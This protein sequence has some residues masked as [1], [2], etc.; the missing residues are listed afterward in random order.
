MNR[1]VL[2]FAIAMLALS[3]CAKKPPKELPPAPVNSTGPVQPE[4]PTSAAV[5]PGSQEDFVASVAADRIF[6]ALDEASVDAEDRATLQ[7]QAGANT[8]WRLGS[9]APT[10]RKTRSLRSAWARTGSARSAMARNGPTRPARTKMLMPA[11]GAR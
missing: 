10:P 3:A 8:I 2:T 6:F 11:T 7:S 4:A 5:V 9:A 1:P